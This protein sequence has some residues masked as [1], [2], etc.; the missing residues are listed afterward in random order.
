MENL[1]Q[2]RNTSTKCTYIPP[3]F[4]EHGGGP[5][6]LMNDTNHKDLIKN[7]KQ[8]P[9]LI[10]KPKAIQVISSHW[11]ESTLTLLETPNPNLLFDYNGFPEET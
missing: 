4:V 5:M 3:I 11:E 7:I 1:N 9:K 8:I 2:I 10:S 6:P